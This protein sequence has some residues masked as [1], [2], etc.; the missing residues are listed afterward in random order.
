MKERNFMT[1]VSKSR[2]VLVLVL[3]LASGLLA[4]AVSA[5]QT[6]SFD[7]AVSGGI[8]PVSV[9]VY[10]NPSASSRGANVL[11]VHGFTE[12]AA[13]WEPLANE[14]F[15]RPGTDR[16][17]RRVIALDLPGHGQSPIPT[18]AAGLFGNLSIYD[19]VGVVIQT[20]DFLRTQGLGARVI[21]GHSMGGLAIQSAQEQLL[22]G[23]SSLAK[24]GV[25]GA[26]LL[27]PVP[28]ANVSWTPAASALPPQYLRF[29]NGTYIVLDAVGALFGGGFSTT[30]STSTMPVVTPAAFALD[31]TDLIGAEPIVTAGQLVGSIP[32]LPRPSARAGAFAVRNGTVLTVIGFSEDILTPASVQPGLYEHLLG[33]R[34]F[35]YEEVVAPDAV[36]SMV[37]T[38]PE[39]LLDQVLAFDDLF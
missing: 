27:A 15:S 3:V 29:D 21:M 28:V 18:L 39:G 22:A 34:G 6:I 23:G 1:I 38:N 32:N 17:I 33:R 37:I 14:L 31:F 35:L 20:I 19:N 25:Y 12:T 11:A 2:A 10:E 4:N 13:M 36:H 24:H 7:A 5:Q 26:I 8:A 30:A 9:T 16:V